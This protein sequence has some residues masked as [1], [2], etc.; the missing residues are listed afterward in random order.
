M[1][2]NIAGFCFYLVFLIHHSSL[3]LVVNSIEELDSDMISRD[4]RLLETFETETECETKKDVHHIYEVII[5]EDG[6]RVKTNI[7]IGNTFNS[8]MCQIKY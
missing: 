5:S 1:L 4:A 7:T 3:E 2:L 6:K 8:L